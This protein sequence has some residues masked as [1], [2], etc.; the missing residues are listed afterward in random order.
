MGLLEAMENESDCIEVI[1]QSYIA[2]KSKKDIFFF[3]R[4][5][6]ILSIML[7]GCHRILKR[8]NMESFIV[9]AR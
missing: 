8:R 4:E 2:S 9:I 5:R 3:L 1:F 6:T 7:V